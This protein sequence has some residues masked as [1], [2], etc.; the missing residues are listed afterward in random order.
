MTLDR[1]V[2]RTAWDKT[3]FLTSVLMDVIGYASYTGWALGP[4]GVGTEATDTIFAP[5]QSAYLMLAYMRWDSLAAAA[6][7]GIEE[8]LPGTDFVPTCTLYHIYAMRKKY[9]PEARQLPAR[10]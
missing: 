3:R 8:I 7:G 5:V 4:V 1:I 9:A 6:V 2:G 10:P